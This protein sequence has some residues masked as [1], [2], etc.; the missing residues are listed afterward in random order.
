MVKLVINLAIAFVSL[1]S[2]AVTTDTSAEQF[3]SLLFMAT[4]SIVHP[5]L[6]SRLEWSGSMDE[7]ISWL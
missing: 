6:L 3:V 4:S 7:I 2:L 5:G 1:L